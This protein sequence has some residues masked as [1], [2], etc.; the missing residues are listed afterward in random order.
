MEREDRSAVEDARAAAEAQAR[1]LRGA[2]DVPAPPGADAGAEQQPADE[3][4]PC[5]MRY[6]PVRPCARSYS[7]GKPVSK[8]R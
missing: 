7:F 1:T 2:E 3:Q 5:T 8:A 6:A 4:L